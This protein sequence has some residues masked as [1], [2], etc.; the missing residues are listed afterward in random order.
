MRAIS[1]FSLEAGISTFWCRA[2]IALRM[3]DSMS[4]TGSVNLIVSFSSSRPFAPR[5][6]E[7]LSAACFYRRTFIRHVVGRS[8]FAI[9]CWLFANDEQRT[10]LLPGRLRNSGDLAPQ[11]QLPETQTAQ[12]KL[13]QKAPRT[14]ANLAPVMLAR[15]ELRLPSV[16]Y[17]FCCSCHLASSSWLLASSNPFVAN[18]GPTSAI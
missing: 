14:S 15:R 5:S 9:R 8:L 16:L 18:F 17:P 4:A 12:A 2:Q 7:N 10:T 13:P 3:R 1:V 6:A 11:R